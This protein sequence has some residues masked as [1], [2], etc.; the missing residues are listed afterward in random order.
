MVA[1]TLWLIFIILLILGLRSGR[2][3]FILAHLISCVC[4]QKCIICQYVL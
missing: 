3:H 1:A 2:A 4:L